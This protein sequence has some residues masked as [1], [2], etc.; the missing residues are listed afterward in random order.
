M[1]FYSSFQVTEENKAIQG[2]LCVGDE[3]LSVNGVHCT[4]R[5]NAIQMVRSID[6]QLHLNIAR[7]VNSFF[8]FFTSLCGNSLRYRLNCP[9]V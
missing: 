6:D 9:N 7:Y 3:I 4:S 1:D 2:E 5:A 8:F